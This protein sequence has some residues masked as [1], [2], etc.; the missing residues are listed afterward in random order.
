MIK[1]ARALRNRLKPSSLNPFQVSV[2]VMMPVPLRSKN[3]TCFSTIVFGR[4]P[5]VKVNREPPSWTNVTSSSSGWVDA[6]G[7]PSWT[8]STVS[9][10]EMT[11]LRGRLAAAPAA[12]R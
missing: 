2:Q 9:P 4:G 5:G 1:T 6:G 12:A 8:V 10:S 7:R 11:S 3:A